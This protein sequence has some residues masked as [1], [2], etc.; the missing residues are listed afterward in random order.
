[1]IAKQKFRIISPK[2]TPN[3]RAKHWTQISH[4]EYPDYERPLLEIPAEILHRIFHRLCFLYGED[5]ARKYLPELERMMK[6]YFA[7]KPSERI[8]A[9]TNITPADRFTEKDIILITYGDLLRS[10][11]SSPL[12]SLLHILEKIPGFKKAINTLHILPFFPYSSDRGFSI[13]DFRNVDPKLGSWQDIAKISESYQLM[14]DAVCNHTSS[15]SKAFQKLLNG[16][17]EYKDIAIV[18]RSPD[19][20]SSEER[21]KIV[22]PR[23]GN[24]LTQFQSLDGPIWV[25]TTFSSDQIDLNY[26][27]PK[28]LLW[29]LETLL[30]YIR[31]G[32]NIIRLDAVTYL[33]K[34]TG[35]SCANLK[36]THETIKLF[37][38]IF[39]VV[40]PG[41]ALITETNI[42]HQQNIAYFG[43]GYDE[44]QMVYNFALP[45]LVL[46]TFYREN[47]SALSEWAKNLEF[48]SDA[49]T[50]LNIL[51]THD[52]IGLMGVRNIL[53]PGEINYLANKAREHGA[54]ISYRTGTNG[55]D[56]PYEIN[57]TWY[58]ALNFDSDNEPLTLQIKRFVASR[59]IALVLKGVPGIYLH[60]LFGTTN[61][62]D[63]VIKTKSKRDINRQ[64]ICETELYEE[65]KLSNSKLYQLTK[66][67]GRLLEIRVRQ[68]AFHPQGKQQVLLLSKQC[69]IV[70]RISPQ[71]NE[72]ILTI[73]NIS[74]QI[75][76][77]KISL[78]ELSLENNSSAINKILDS[79][80]WYD[81]VGNRGWKVQHQKISLVVQPYE[82]I[83]LMP[84]KELERSIET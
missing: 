49:C 18:Y 67:L 79:S 42:P 9:E 54:F 60:G 8:A 29:V 77:L 28:V 63:A 26:R 76:H 70:L 83:W 48:P 43:N 36:Q 23:T 35:T 56:E 7:Y 58:S 32:A 57:S 84:D 22:R 15:K 80:Y 68:K 17:P 72:H 12:A 2:S 30:L 71:N 25:W 74:R 31:R 64:I 38:D 81:L 78:K 1:M 24:L 46:H 11:H 13:T 39:N 27:N 50:Y 3:S 65:L 69:F 66:T 41:V 55:R 75:C 19:E 73:V 59:S 20:L 47:T 53:P 21:Q 14:F 16:S 82:V 4:Y 6:V 45:P 5:Q 33:W 34:I 51:D 61:D 44:A 52:G 40:A 10:E 62:V 37:R